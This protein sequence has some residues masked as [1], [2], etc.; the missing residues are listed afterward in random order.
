MSTKPLVSILLLSLFL[1]AVAASDHQFDDDNQSQRPWLQRCRQQI[2]SGERLRHCERLLT[3]PRRFRLLL[4][5]EEEEDAVEHLEEC[6]QQLKGM[7][8]ACRCEGL[9]QIVQRRRQQGQLQGV[10]VGQMLERATNLP[11]V[12][13][14]SRRRCDLRS[15]T[16]L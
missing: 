5:A 16:P 9:R 11:S 8:D 7:D 14:L 10:D 1:F 15:T 13:R 6:C 2:R 12:C 3:Q 4:A